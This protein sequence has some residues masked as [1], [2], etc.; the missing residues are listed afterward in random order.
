MTS[1]LLPRVKLLM[2][3]TPD[4]FQ[5]FSSAPAPAEDPEMVFLFMHETVQLD[6]LP[7]RPGKT[8]RKN[9]SMDTRQLQTLRQ[10]PAHAT[11]GGRKPGHGRSNSDLPVV[12]PNAISIKG[13]L[14]TKE[15]VIGIKQVYDLLKNGHSFE[16]VKAGVLSGADL[17][18]VG[19]AVR[20]KSLSFDEL[21]VKVF[22]G[23]SQK[24]L[25]VLQQWV[26]EYEQD[27]PKKEE[28][29][30]QQVSFNSLAEFQYLFDIYDTNKNG[31]LSLLEL[32]SALSHM[33][34]TKDIEQ[35]FTQY[36]ENHDDKISLTEF[37]KMMAPEGKEVTFP[38][39]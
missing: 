35:M 23:V 7:Q 11:N 1:K 38:P 18:R 24:D 2:R 14:V 9:P 3:L 20:G 34:S 30:L 6:K 10:P 4:L 8:H 27:T 37:M 15:Q 31:E 28:P 12:K 21:L 29:V 26:L 22:K 33:F 25:R 32:K 36:D 19:E 39:A 16:E 17:K 13:S 5:L